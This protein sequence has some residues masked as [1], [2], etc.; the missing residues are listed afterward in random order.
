MKKKY[1]YSESEQKKQKDSF[2]NKKENAKIE[3][4]AF[5]SY[6]ILWKKKK[7]NKMNSK[8]D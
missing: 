3:R 7:R 4:N 1:K 6:T 5:K 8:K 2:K